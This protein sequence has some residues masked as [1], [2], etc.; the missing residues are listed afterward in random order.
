MAALERR[1]GRARGRGAAGRLVAPVQAVGDEAVLEE[2]ARV[3]EGEASRLRSQHD[4]KEALARAPGG[5]GQVVARLVGE[6][7]LQRLHAAGIV[8]ER[9]A[10]A[11]HAPTVDEGLSAQDRARGGIVGDEVDR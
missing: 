10:P 5:D 9:D 7:R 2:L 1:G 11:V 3:A 8:E 6:P 4:Q